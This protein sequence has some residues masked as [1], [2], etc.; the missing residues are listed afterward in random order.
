MDSGQVASAGATFDHC[1]LND[2]GGLLLC[3]SLLHTCIAA[4]SRMIA[5]FPLALHT[6]PSHPP[7]AQSLLREAQPV[8]EGRT[9]DHPVRVPASRHQLD[10]LLRCM[11]A[12]RPVILAMLSSGG[13]LQT[14]EVKQAA[15]RCDGAGAPFLP[16]PSRTT[17]RAVAWL[18]CVCLPPTLCI[19]PGLHIRH[20]RLFAFVRPPSNPPPPHAHS[21]MHMCS[22][23][24]THGEECRQPMAVEPGA[25]VEDQAARSSTYHTAL[26]HE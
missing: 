1:C 16:G 11:V 17:W 8:A 18:Q 6:L 15:Y 26:M 3:C 13:N 2:G 24:N 25:G 23:L 19:F 10:L 21:R 20:Q 14:R 4:S 22:Y 9:P 12:R 7:R 5:P